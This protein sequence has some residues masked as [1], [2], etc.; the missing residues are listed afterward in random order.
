MSSLLSQT[1]ISVKDAVERSS[2]LGKILDLIHPRSTSGS[3][4]SS[5]SILLNSGWEGFPNCADHSVQCAGNHLG[6]QG[7]GQ[8]YL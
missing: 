4:I 6:H 2:A 1:Q 8:V 7:E 3:K 5:S